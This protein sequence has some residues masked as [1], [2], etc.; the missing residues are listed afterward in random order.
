MCCNGKWLFYLFVCLALGSI[1]AQ[2]QGP[3]LP[4]ARVA[5]VRDSIGRLLAAEPKRDTT[6]VGRLNALA[7]IL[8]TNEAP[9]SQRLA[10][11]A[12][13]LAQQLKFNKGLVE[14][15]FN[16]GYSFRALNQYDS[17]IYYSRRALDLSQ[18]I[19]NRYTQTRAYYNLA[20]IYTEQGNYAAALG[21]SLDGLALARTIHN[22]RAE[23][24]QLV[25]AGRIELALGEYTAAN[26]HV[27]EASRLVPA[28]HDPLGTGYVQ[29]A[30]GEP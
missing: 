24:F 23:L 16:M 28:A 14:A 22:A 12:L 18:F 2:A 17:A 27:F 25:Q 9:Q 8:R 11:Q 19:G 1:A 21:P 29:F 15:H 4:L 13:A 7:F 20:R 30:L 26:A 10:R 6:R 5:A 3:P